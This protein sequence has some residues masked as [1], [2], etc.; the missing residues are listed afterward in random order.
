MNATHIS[1]AARLLSCTVP[2]SFITF[3]LPYTRVSRLQWRCQNLSTTLLALARATR[4]SSISCSRPSSETLWYRSKIPAT[5]RKDAAI[6]H[7]QSSRVGLLRT[8]D[9]FLVPFVVFVYFV[10]PLRTPH[11]VLRHRTPLTSRPSLSASAR[12]D[13]LSVS[14]PTT[15]TTFTLTSQ[16]AY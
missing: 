1:R 9:S 3:T 16:M 7:R 2:V 10:L 4:Q 12:L 15:F 5:P 11:I 13:Y 6:I 14:K 8:I